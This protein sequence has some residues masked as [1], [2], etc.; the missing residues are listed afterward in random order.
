MKFHL[1]KNND[2]C[3]ES[4][5]WRTAVWDVRWGFQFVRYWRIYTRTIF[6]IGRRGSKAAR[7]MFRFFLFFYPCPE[8]NRIFVQA[9]Q[10]CESF[11]SMVTERAT[12][13]GK[14]LTSSTLALLSVPSQNFRYNCTLNSFS[15]LSTCIVHLFL[16]NYNSKNL[17]S[18]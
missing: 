5:S 2:R 16:E 12:D 9:S 4:C 18:Q 7:A 6:V 14:L 15:L 10:L 17:I 11:G 8:P 13:A 1:P 3:V